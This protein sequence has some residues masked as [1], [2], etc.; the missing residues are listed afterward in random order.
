MTLDEGDLIYTGTPKGVSKVEK[1]DTI[2]AGIEG[3]AELKVTVE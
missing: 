1:G 3:L 2:H